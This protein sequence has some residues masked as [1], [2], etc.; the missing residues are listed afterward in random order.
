[1]MG[2]GFYDSLERKRNVVHWCTLSTLSDP[3]DTYLYKE[4]GHDCTETG[5]KVE[6][7]DALF[8]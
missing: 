4:S 5:V 7:Y 3:L 6:K 8:Q 2:G 1:M